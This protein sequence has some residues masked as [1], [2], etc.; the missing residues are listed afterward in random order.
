[1]IQE[2]SI[3][4]LCFGY[5]LLERCFLNIITN[6]SCCAGCPVCPVVLYSIESICVSRVFGGISFDALFW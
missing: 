6:A 5:P 3:L 4:E 2:K 1:M